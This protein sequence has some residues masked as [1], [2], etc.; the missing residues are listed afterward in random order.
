MKISA[1]FVVTRYTP[2]L[3]LPILI[4]VPV[5]QILTSSELAILS[6]VAFAWLWEDGALFSAALLAADGQLSVMQAFVAIF[7]G[8]VSGDF[9][10]YMCG[11][12]AIRC[13]WLRLRLLSNRRVRSVAY[14]LR[15]RLWL[16][17]LLIRFVPGL[18]TLG[19]TLC[20]YWRV[21]WWEF[22]L[23]ISAAGLVWIALVF[24]AVYSL[25]SSEAFEEGHLKWWLMGGALMIFLITNTPWRRF[26]YGR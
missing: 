5:D 26:A 2:R 1:R 9:A 16:N 12:L 17:L 18:R 8:I 11:R 20:G 3:S 15:R 13:S 23:I 4:G 25:G 19:F 7:V 24:S 14:R 10:L 6:V 22:L 21:L